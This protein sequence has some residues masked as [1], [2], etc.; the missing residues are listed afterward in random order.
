MQLVQSIVNG[1][2]TDDNVI[3][4]I[5]WKRRMP[6]HLLTEM[7]EKKINGIDYRLK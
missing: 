2:G 1:C 3:A 4:L 6:R 7:A 5:A